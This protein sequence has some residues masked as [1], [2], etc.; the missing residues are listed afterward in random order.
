MRIRA[1]AIVIAMSFLAL[2]VLPG[3]CGKK[4]SNPVKPPNPPPVDYGV[5]RIVYVQYAGSG[6]T[7]S[8]YSM[9][10]DGTGQTAIP[11]EVSALSN[12][13]ISPD[14]TKVLFGARRNNG[15]SLYT[16]DIDGSNLRSIVATSVKYGGWSPDVS[17]VAYTD[18]SG[19]LTIVNADGSNPVIVTSLY[20]KWNYDPAWS[21]DGTRIAFYSDLASTTYR[22]DI[23]VINTD[24]TGMT[25]ITT[26]PGDEDG[27]DWSPDGTQ[28]AFASRG[29]NERGI[30]TVHPD[31][32][33]LKRLT[34][35]PD[36]AYTDWFPDWSPDGKR[37][38]FSSDRANASSGDP[39]ALFSV[40]ADGTG[41]VQLTHPGTAQSQYSPTWGPK[42]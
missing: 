20:P 15:D 24:G 19:A 30:Y 4:G 37:I 6:S 36:P 39:F 38:V 18:D 13:Q 28:I 14:G 17:K 22:T 26:L 42:P 27:P 9:N 1:R 32:T 23:Y 12:A 40:N 8:I 25:R 41:L 29:T 35:A 21:P 10:P 3:G 33:G 11:T 7:G 2:T 5:G 34:T 31:G 16:M